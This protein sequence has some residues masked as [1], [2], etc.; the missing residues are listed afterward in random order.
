M[1]EVKI[2]QLILFDPALEDQIIVNDVSALVTK[3]STLQSIRDLAN[4]NI[5]DTGSGSQVTGDLAVTGDICG[6]TLCGT[7]IDDLVTQDEL[8][9]ILPPGNTLLCLRDSAPTRTGGDCGVRILGET[10]IDSDLY[11]DGVAYGDGAGIFNIQ[12]AEKSDS[13]ARSTESI[14]SDFADFADVARYADS[15]QRSLEAYY[16][17]RQQVADAG[18]LAA[19]HFM[20][21]SQLDTGID[22]VNT[23]ASLQ[24]N[25]NTNILSAEFFQGDGSLLT[26]IVTSQASA[27]L[28]S[29]TQAVTNEAYHLLFFP[30]S[31]VGGQDSV[32][33]DAN[34]LY[35]HVSNT[36]YDPANSLFLDGTA[37][38]ARKMS[39]KD[40]TG[41]NYV[42]LREN[43]AGDSDSCSVSSG[44]TW[45]QLTET[46]N[47]TNFDGDGSALTNVDAVT[48][49]TAT[50]VNVTSVSDD[51]QYYVHL[52]SALSGGDGVNTT[53]DFRYNPNDRDLIID[54]DN[55]RITLGADSDVTIGVAR[56]V[57]YSFDVVNNG[58]T[59]YRFT[60]KASIWFP[61]AEDNPILYLR[62]GDTYRFDMNAIGHPLEI[63]VSSG[64]AAYNTGVTN[65][66]EDG[67]YI[68]FSVPMSAPSTLYYQ[69]T[70][71]GVMGNTINIV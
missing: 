1:A 23:D 52:G 21:F 6:A 54:Q 55:A 68:Y 50:N 70:V 10:T 22:S 59:T 2:S 48:A 8:D 11:W 56:N 42:M 30:S 63:R 43:G 41:T 28:L 27:D 53:G 35:N 9:A 18:D 14:T 47:A 45:D 61:S 3:R 32:N 38:T 31:G 12:F 19:P 46:L 5:D 7:P 15:S 40:A 49:I 60:D 4:Q 66:A 20:L 44:I 39:A 29:P 67:G 24:F 71:H 36:I 37:R 62:R 25:P 64:G 34:L 13:A 65:N 51:L 69:C 16:S 58:T 33:I 26:N 57:Q 17:I